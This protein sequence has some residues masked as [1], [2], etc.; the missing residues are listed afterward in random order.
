LFGVIGQAG[1]VASGR[2][3]GAGMS[4]TGAWSEP[5][6]SASSG[7]PNRA[8]LLKVLAACCQA[9]TLMNGLVAIFIHLGKRTERVFPELICV[10]FV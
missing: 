4:M 3:W 1:A 7:L 6:D 5:I 8:L 9:L 2:W 10:D